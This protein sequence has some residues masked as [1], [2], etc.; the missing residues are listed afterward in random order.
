MKKN[1]VATNSYP[2]RH[3]QIIGF[4]SPDWDWSY[5]DANITIPLP[6]SQFR[7]WILFLRSIFFMICDI[8]RLCR[9]RSV[10]WGILCLPITVSIYILRMLLIRLSRLCK[11]GRYK[12]EGILG[13]GRRQRGVSSTTTTWVLSPWE[14]KLK[15]VF[16]VTATVSKKV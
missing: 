3:D 15:L 10:I 16:L 13:E 7:T 12:I 6:I 4:T 9:F 14:W 11:L 5:C 8:I 2:A 1:F